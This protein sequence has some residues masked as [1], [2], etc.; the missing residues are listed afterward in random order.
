MV[1]VDIDEGEKMRAGLVSLVVAVTEILVET[2]SREAVRR[3]ETGNLSQ[4]EINDLGRRLERL[5]NEI[6]GLKKDEGVEGDVA[7][8]RGKL[9]GLIEDAVYGIEQS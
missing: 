5:E 4:E 6:E 3:M 1:E 7:E 2:M 8:L 9:N